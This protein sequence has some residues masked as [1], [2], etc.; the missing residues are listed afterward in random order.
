MAAKNPTAG[1]Y[2]S[3]K[4]ENH[5]YRAYEIGSAMAVLHYRWNKVQGRPEVAKGPLKTTLYYFNAITQLAN[6]IFV[7]TRTWQV[8]YQSEAT[9]TQK[10]LCQFMA[11]FW[12]YSVLLLFSL[13][14]GDTEVSDFT[15]QTMKYLQGTL[16]CYMT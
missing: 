6:L 13:L 9:P 2:F 15:K 12:T 8:N 11:V 3:R 5:I 16:H 1:V 10:F 14:Q 4:M 7:Y